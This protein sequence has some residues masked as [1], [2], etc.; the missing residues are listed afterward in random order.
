MGRL[1]LRQE[2][3]MEPANTW[4]AATAADD[5]AVVAM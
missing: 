3:H 1:V 2:A 5:E 4:R